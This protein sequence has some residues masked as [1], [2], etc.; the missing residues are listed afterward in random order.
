MDDILWV[1]IMIMSTAIYGLSTR[2]VE[3]ETY[4]VAIEC[5]TT[6]PH[7]NYGW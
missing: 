1:V 7:D 4:G 3:R 6:Q 2:N 5:P